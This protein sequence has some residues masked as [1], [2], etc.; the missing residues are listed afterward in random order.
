MKRK[1]G[2]LP[3]ALDGF[4]VTT[5]SVSVFLLAEKSLEGL[6]EIGKYFSLDVRSVGLLTLATLLYILGHVLR[7][8]RLYLI[9][10]V[11]RL[12]F[13]AL[14][15]FHSAVAFGTLATPYKLGEPVRA[16]EAYRL[17]SNDMLG[18][19]SV[20]LDRLFDVAII[21]LTSGILIFLF[22]YRE[23]TLTILYAAGIF[24]LF[25]VVVVLILPGAVA[26]LG[27]VMLA[28]SSRRSMIILQVCVFIR[29]IL[30]AIPHLD[31]AMISLLTVLTVGIWSLEVGTVFAIMISLSSGDIS[32]VQS[33]L[34]VFANLLAFTPDISI[35]PL[36]LYRVISVIGLALL[37]SFTLRHYLRTRSK[38]GS[39]GAATSTY[40][41]NDLFYSPRLRVKGR[42]R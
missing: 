30:S 4:T 32:L 18:V 9:M 6:Q 40:V 16:V 1:A 25:S 19:F 36:A 21:L 5:I 39:G 17:L 12:R 11:G 24:L 42:T 13:S 7:A 35:I 23:P 38:A 27:R 8:I 37:C 10:G 3:Y 28:S 2:W 29:G 33:S 15:G 31:G 26:S 22:G 14:L 20:W 41:C 34:Q